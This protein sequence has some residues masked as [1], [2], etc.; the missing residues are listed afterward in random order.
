MVPFQVKCDAKSF[1]SKLSDKTMESLLY[2]IIDDAGKVIGARKP[3]E[4]VK[5]E[6]LEYFNDKMSSRRV[7][8]NTMLNLFLR[9]L[10]SSV[11]NFFSNYLKVI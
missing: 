3:S 10:F 6:H 5:L 8:T 4:F 1:A 2:P 9:D 11:S 7:L